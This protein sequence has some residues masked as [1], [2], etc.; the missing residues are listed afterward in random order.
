M[1][2]NLFNGIKETLSSVKGV[3]LFLAISLLIFVLLILIPVWTTPG[4]DF[5]FQLSILEPFILG[6]LI[7]LSLANGLLLTMQ[8]HIRAVVRERKSLTHHVARAGTA[9]G[10]VVS[11]LISTVACAAC[12]SAVLAVFGLGTTAFVVQH[13]GWFAVAALTITGAAIYYSAR[14]INHNCEVCEVK[15]PV[16]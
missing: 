10:V 14:R 16:A 5:L 2:S 4:N 13:R 15:L 8:L 7:V 12:Y 11:S 9:M 3:A 6:L 1:F